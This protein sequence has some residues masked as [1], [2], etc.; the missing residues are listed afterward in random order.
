MVGTSAPYTIYKSNG[1]TWISAGGGGSTT[2]VGL[3]DSVSSNIV[4]VNTSVASLAAA[5]RTASTAWVT[6]WTTSGATDYG[7]F[8]ITAA[9]ALTSN[10]TSSIVGGYTRGVLIADGSHVPTFDGSTISNWVN[11]AGARNKVELLRVGNSKFW[12]V[13][14]NVGTAIVV[15]YDG[16]TATSTDIGIALDG[17]TATSTDSSTAVDGG[18]ATS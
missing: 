5:T 11:T 14:N 8:T 3:T 9:T 16:G 2:F 7:E 10:D 6:A 17:G 4:S 13:G 18:T 12:T 1:S 15:A